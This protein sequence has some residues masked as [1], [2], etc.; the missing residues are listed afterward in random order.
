MDINPLIPDLNKYKEELIDSIQIAIGFNELHKADRYVAHDII[1]IK[2]EQYSSDPF[3]QVANFYN[4]PREEVVKNIR[5]FTNK[6]FKTFL[7]GDP[8]LIKDIEFD[9]VEAQ[10]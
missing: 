1:G 2:G 10:G 8:K 9:S 3:Q 5:T 4:L 6:G 7:P